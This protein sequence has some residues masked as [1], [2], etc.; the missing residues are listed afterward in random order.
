[1]SHNA[2]K[3]TVTLWDASKNKV[4]DDYVNNHHRFTTEVEDRCLKIYR[5]DLEH[6]EEKLLV[7]CYANQQWV[8]YEWEYGPE[9]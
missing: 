6:S 5:C 8:S 3:L 4:T 1:M 7:K 2:L 9:H